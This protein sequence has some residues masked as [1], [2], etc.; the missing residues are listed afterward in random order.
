MQICIYS[1]SS[2][3]FKHRIWLGVHLISKFHEKSPFEID[4]AI[5]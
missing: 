2:A 5:E 3:E 4:C 1:K